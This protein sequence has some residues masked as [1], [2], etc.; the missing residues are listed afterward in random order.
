VLKVGQVLAEKYRLERILGSGGFAAVWAARNIEIDRPVALKVLAD[1][2]TQKEAFVARFLREARLAAKPI[3]GTIVRVEDICKTDDGV[4]FLVMEL[5]EG[6]TLQDE[7][8]ARGALPQAECLDLIVLLLQGLGAAHAKGI[9]HRDIKPTNIFLTTP[10][11]PG[12]RLRILDLGLAKD[13]GTDEQL[14]RTGETMGTPDFLAPE[15]LLPNQPHTSGCEIDVFS[16]GVV[17]YEMITGRRPLDGLLSRSSTTTAFVQ[18]AVFYQTGTRLPPPSEHVAIPESLEVVICRALEIDPSKRYRDATEMLLAL[19]SSMDALTQAPTRH[20]RFVEDARTEPVRLGEEQT[21]VYAGSDL[22]TTPAHVAGSPDDL[23]AEPSLTT[24]PEDKG[25]AEDEVPTIGVE[26]R[27]ALVPAVESSDPQPSPTEE[28]SQLAGAAFVAPGRQWVTGF[29][30]VGIIVGL[31]A[32][33][34][35]LAIIAWVGDGEPARPPTSEPRPSGSAA[36]RGG[37]LGAQGPGDRDVGAF[38]AE[39]VDIAATVPDARDAPER[40]GDAGAGTF[41]DPPPAS[42]APMDAAALRDGEQPRVQQGAQDT[43]EPVHQVKVP[44]RP[45]PRR[46][47]PVSTDVPIPFDEIGGG[48]SVQPTAGGAGPRGRGTTPSTR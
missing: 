48:G 10:E 38:A 3:H 29:A 46:P 43:V 2:L 26:F 32:L 12:P 9:V 18:R 31:L 1:I 14:T 40:G 30:V 16:A 39:R 41:A 35:G 21:E 11:T 4:P 37:G 19:E 28:V 25:P 15:Q 36:D 22:I 24:T 44:Q 33:A 7:I 20:V 27:P 17:L 45:P 13:L 6:R 5:L 8:K 42:E 23:G 34:S 47:P